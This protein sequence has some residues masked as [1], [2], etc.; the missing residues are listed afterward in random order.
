MIVGTGVEIQGGPSMVLQMVY[1][2]HSA[3]ALERSKNSQE[4]KIENAK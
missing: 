2:G 3:N 1:P 4:A